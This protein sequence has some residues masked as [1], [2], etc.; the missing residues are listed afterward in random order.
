LHHLSAMLGLLALLASGLL[1]GK[2]ARRVTPAAEI[3]LLGLVTAIVLLEF[4]SWSRTGGSTAHDLLEWILPA[5][6]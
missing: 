5:I 2:L 4:A 1:V 6:R 3:L